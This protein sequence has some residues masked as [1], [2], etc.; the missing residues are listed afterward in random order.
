M[1]LTAIWVHGNAVRAQL[2]GGSGLT[3]PGP[4]EQVEGV[5]WTDL[6]GFP[7]GWGTTYRCRNNNSNW[8]HFSIPTPAVLNDHRYSV[9]RVFVFYNAE[10]SARLTQI[11]AWDGAKCIQ[12]FPVAGSG[13]DFTHIIVDNV[14]AWFLDSKMQWGL[15][16][17]ANFSFGE[18]A[19]NVTFAAA[20]ADFDL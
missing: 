20:G 2:I 7:R 5:P 13:G 15:G 18:T 10:G 17:S 11:D 16:I 8:F 12:S 9:K 6:A 4:N 19:S 14:N 3:S 1:A